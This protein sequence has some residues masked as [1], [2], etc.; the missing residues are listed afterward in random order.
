MR[1]RSLR[2]IAVLL[3]AAAAAAT[4][5]LVLSTTGEAGSE[6]SATYSLQHAQ[7]LVYRNV[8]ADR[9]YKAD[10]VD[11]LPYPPELVILGGSRAVRFEPSRFARLTGLPGFNAAFLKGRPEDSWA[12]VKHMLALWPGTKLHCF[13]ALQ[14]TSFVD[15]T[16]HPGLV[17]DRRLSRYFPRD[18]IARQ[19]ALLGHVRAYDLLHNRVYARDGTTLWNEYDVFAQR[20]RTLDQSLDV[21]LRRLLPVAASTTTPKQTRSRRYFEKTIALFNGIGVK[22]VIV[23]MPYQPRVLAAFRAVGWERK[24]DAL[25]AYLAGLQRAGL[26]FVVLDY[27]EIAS[28]NGDANGFYDGAH[29]TVANA[30]RVIRQAVRDA[31]GAF[32]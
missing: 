9:S 24:V 31:P 30:R 23:I 1:R 12:F 26:R 25:R 10:L 5:Y 13:W 18:L 22:P 11:G 14:G 28:F 15:G 29:I 27:L 8:G 3:V 16:L 32:R 19:A 20:G 6:Q 21:Y 17:Y 4:V 2:P 7:R